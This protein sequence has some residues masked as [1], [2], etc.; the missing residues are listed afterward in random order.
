MSGIKRTET[1]VRMSKIVEHNNTVYL[2]GQVA[3]D[4]SK[5][6]KEQTESVLEKID[7]LLAQ[8]GSDKD[9][10]LSVTIYLKSIADDFSA[11]NEV[12]EAWLNEGSAPAR[13]CVEA[14]MAR[15]ALLV[16][17]SVI[18]AKKA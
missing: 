17:M 5:G 4:P 12:W 7:A 16:E 15:E 11:M 1:S 18:A 14:R 6:I 9:S 10:I 3:A 2:C 8:A 13:A